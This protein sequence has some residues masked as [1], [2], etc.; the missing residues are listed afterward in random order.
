MLFILKRSITIFRVELEFGK[1]IF[2][3]EIIE[4]RSKSGN[5]AEDKICRGRETLR[6]R[7]KGPATVEE[8]VSF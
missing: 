5:F 6:L 2:I 1:H 7:P 3:A 8:M 4:P